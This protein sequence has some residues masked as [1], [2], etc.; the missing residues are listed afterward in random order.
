MKIFIVMMIVIIISLFVVEN[1]LGQ[2]VMTT[3]N[4]LITVTTSSATDTISVSVSGSIAIPGTYTL[5]EGALMQDLIE[6]A[7][8]VTTDADVNC[9]TISYRL[10]NK[11]TYYIAHIT[12][13]AK[14]SLNTAT[15]EELTTLPGIGITYAS[16]IIEYRNTNAR[17]NAL[18]ELLLIQGIG[19]TSFNK[20]KDLICL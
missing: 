4:S 11:S 19:T 9:Y 20:I 16:R 1:V 18:E 3:S 12:E 10:T 14:I 6:A 5:N 8:G 2:P 17:F 7:G 15:S 13:A